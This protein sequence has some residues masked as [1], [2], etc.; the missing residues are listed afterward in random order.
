MRLY[1]Q[2]EDHLCY[3]SSYICKSKEK[4]EKFNIE[5]IITFMDYPII[6]M[7][8]NSITLIYTIYYHIS[9]ILTNGFRMH[10]KQEKGLN[11][12]PYVHMSIAWLKYRTVP[13]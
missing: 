6:Q 4:L 5:T 7:I 1:A 2:I 13:R 12:Y 10:N 8:F 3:R 9:M 11:V